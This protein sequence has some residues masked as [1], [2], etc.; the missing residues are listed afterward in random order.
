MNFD[1]PKPETTGNELLDKEMLSDYKGEI[2]KAK[3]AVMKAFGLGYFNQ[4]QTISIL[5]KLQSQSNALKKP[6]KITVKAIKVPKISLKIKKSRIVTP[7]KMKISMPKAKSIKI[8]AETPKKA[9]LTIKT[10]IG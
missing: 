6:K 3:N 7:K 4:E 2:T 5:E 10:K 9:N 8:K 1:I